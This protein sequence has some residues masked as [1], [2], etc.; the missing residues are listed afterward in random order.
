MS[1]GIS[2]SPQY[3]YGINH[4]R[5]LTIACYNLT[6][7]FD[8]LNSIP[9]EAIKKKNLVSIYNEQ[10]NIK[11]GIKSKKFQ[12]GPFKIHIKKGIPLEPKQKFNTTM[13]H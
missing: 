6:D 9:S 13:N 12:Y 8:Q 11:G 2:K 4:F 10:K 7:Q 1:R 3:V 5:S